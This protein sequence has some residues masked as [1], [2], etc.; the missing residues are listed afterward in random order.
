MRESRSE[1]VG[2]SRAAPLALDGS[3]GNA[4]HLDENPWI[5]IQEFGHAIQPAGRIALSYGTD[6]LA[7]GRSHVRGCALHLSII[8]RQMADVRCERD[9]VACEDTLS[10]LAQ[11]ASIQ[12]LKSAHPLRI[13][14]K[15]IASATIAPATGMT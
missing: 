7:Y 5:D 13:F 1:A 6:G 3:S 14:G 10:A 4:Q 11:D 2:L 9:G 15:P 12:E 8:I